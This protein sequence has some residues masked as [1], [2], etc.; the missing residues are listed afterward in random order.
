MNTIP[1]CGASTM[2][3]FYLLFFWI[4]ALFD[5]SIPCQCDALRQIRLP[6]ILV[7]DSKLGGISAT[8][9]AYDS[10][11]IRGY[12]VV[13]V[14]LTISPELDNAEYISH[15]LR[16]Q[17]HWIGGQR[18]IVVVLPELPKKYDGMKEAMITT[19]TNFQ[20]I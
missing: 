13:A 11:L 18:P 1:S 8:L 19:N 20:S 6:S 9:T 7:A 10:L 4:I 2:L 17:M 14:V 3:C 15:N 16:K 5:K 12:D